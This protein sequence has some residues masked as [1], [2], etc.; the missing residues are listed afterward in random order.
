MLKEEAIIT[1]WS[2][3]TPAWVQRLQRNNEIATKRTIHEPLVKEIVVAKNSQPEADKSK[4]D[5]TRTKT[6]SAIDTADVASPVGPLLLRLSEAEEAETVAATTSP[7]SDEDLDRLRRDIGRFLEAHEPFYVPTAQLLT[8]S[9]RLS[10]LRGD[11]GNPLHFA[12][13]C[14]VLDAERH[15]CTSCS[16]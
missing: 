8:N 13:F 15:S 1:N 14:I 7:S 10:M 9:V 3:L 2:S 12:V 11:W 16:A 5:S 4:G 6:T